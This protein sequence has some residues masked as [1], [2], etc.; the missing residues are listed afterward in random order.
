MA[1]PLLEDAPVHFPSNGMVSMEH[2]SAH[3]LPIIQ[4]NSQSRHLPLRTEIRHKI[5]QLVLGSFNVR[6]CWAYINNEANK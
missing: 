2:L 1:E 5:F 4:H 6:P 3:L